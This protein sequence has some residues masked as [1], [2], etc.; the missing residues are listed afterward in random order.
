MKKNYIF[1]HNSIK[2]WGGGTKG[3]AVMSANNVSFFLTA[4]LIKACFEEIEM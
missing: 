4:P 3:L 2:A 1:A